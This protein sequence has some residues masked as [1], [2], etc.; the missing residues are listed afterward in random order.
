MDGGRSKQFHLTEGEWYARQKSDFAR[1]R[2]IGPKLYS[3]AL[4]HLRRSS[5][6]MDVDVNVLLCFQKP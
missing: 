3:I 4:A 2:E 5:K 6:L 1:E